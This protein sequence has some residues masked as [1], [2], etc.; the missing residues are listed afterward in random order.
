MQTLLL[1]IL[2]FFLFLFF[3]NRKG[4]VGLGWW[5]E[6]WPFLLYQCLLYVNWALSNKTMGEEYSW[7]VFVEMNSNSFPL[8]FSFIW[9]VRTWWAD[10]FHWKPKP[11]LVFLLPVNAD[12]G[13]KELATQTC[14]I[15]YYS[16]VLTIVLLLLWY[17]DDWDLMLFYTMTHKLFFGKALFSW[18]LWEVQENSTVTKI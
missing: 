2:H 13:C 3:T 11:F 14:Q 16:T 17:F 12:S 18:L 5:I 6:D 15:Q 8:L 10:V 9:T 7:R 4:L 1:F